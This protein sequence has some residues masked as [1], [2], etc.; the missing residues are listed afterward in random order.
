VC[1][2]IHSYV[3]T[4]C[5]VYDCHIVDAVTDIYSMTPYDSGVQ[6]VAVC[7]SVLQCV[8]VCCSVLQCVAV[9]CSVSQ[10]FAVL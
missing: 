4:S 3:D 9:C 1:Y 8:A 2:S 7:C 6:C 5:D 10:Y